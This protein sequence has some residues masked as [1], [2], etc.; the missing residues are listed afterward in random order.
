M[1]LFEVKEVSEAD[2]MAEASKRTLLAGNAP[3]ANMV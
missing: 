2:A 3:D 1:L